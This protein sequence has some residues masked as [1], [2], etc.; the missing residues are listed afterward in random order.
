MLIIGVTGSLGSGKSYF[1]EAFSKIRRVKYISS[2]KMVHYIYNHNI[3]VINFVKNN[4]PE[5]IVENKIN[6]KILGNII[7]NN[8]EKKHNLENYIYPILKKQRQKIIR[9]YATKK[10]MILLVE[11]PLL[12]ENNLEK[13]C[14]YTI[15][16]HCN[17][18]LQKQRALKR[19]GMTEEKFNLIISSQMSLGEKLKKSSFSVNTG[20]NIQKQIGYIYNYLIKG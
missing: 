3:E 12:F 5:A 17:K 19:A 13:E 10:I 4:F 18:I 20:S 9:E 16:V 6:R 11:I 2:D 14:D 15:T 7:F 1:C 8:D